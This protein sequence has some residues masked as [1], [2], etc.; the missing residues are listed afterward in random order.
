MRP[1]H[2]KRPQTRSGKAEDGSRLSP[3]PASAALDH[4]DSQ[5]IRAPNLQLAASGRYV[6]DLP[7]CCVRHIYP[8]QNANTFYN[9]PRAR[10]SIVVDLSGR[11][12]SQLCLWFY[13]KLRRRISIFRGFARRVLEK[14]TDLVQ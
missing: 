2:R 8:R 12:L 5:V 4:D 7:K 6:A 10:T 3:H 11:P 1:K 14:L 9:L 13:T